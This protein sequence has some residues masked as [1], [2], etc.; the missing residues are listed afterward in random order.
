MTDMTPEEIAD[1]DSAERT[2]A[3]INAY[4]AKHKIGT[5]KPAMWK[6]LAWFWVVMVVGI[7]MLLSVMQ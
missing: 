7:I 6:Q 5:Y 3:Q 1:R 4:C 2:L